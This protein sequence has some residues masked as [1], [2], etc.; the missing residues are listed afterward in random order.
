MNKIQPQIELFP[1]FIGNLPTKPYC[2]DDLS[3]GLKIR[4]RD[5]ALAFK[6]IQPNS[7]FYQHYFVLDLDY[8]SALSEIL[9]S[10]NG[11]PMPNFVA[12]NPQNGR[13]HAFFE[14][15]TPIYTTDASRQ[16]PIMLANAIY[17]R[18][19]ELFNA[20]VGYSGLISKNPMHEQWHTYSIRKKPY[21]LNELSS[22]LDISWLDVKKAPKQDEAVGLGRNCYIFHTARHWAYVEIR[23]YRG[24]TYSVWLQC[25]IDHCL[26]LNESIL[27]PMQYN[28]IKGIAKSISRYCWKKDAY[29]YQEFIDRQSRKGRLGGLKGGKSRSNS[30]VAQ[31]ILALEMLRNGQTQKKVATELNVSERTIRNWIKNEI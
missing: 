31:R 23:K 9:Y 16:K 19:R 20:D 15:K 18:L 12:E 28:E 5:T 7:P 30:Y 2:T 6:Y 3:T 14:L 24:K 4:P 21:S 17:L 11:V 27:E 29:C 25:V 13:L 1:S 26:K 22:K 8:E 10:L